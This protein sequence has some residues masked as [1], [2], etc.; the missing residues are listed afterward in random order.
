MSTWI[1]LLII[2]SIQRNFFPADWEKLR[3]QDVLSQ[4]K[5]ASK[6]VKEDVSIQTE[7]ELKETEVEVIM[8]PPIVKKM[9]KEGRM[10]IEIKETT[11]IKTKTTRIVL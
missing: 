6:K 8:E 1:S 4:R 9:P 11:V 5:K 7:E 3:T 2:T 10:S